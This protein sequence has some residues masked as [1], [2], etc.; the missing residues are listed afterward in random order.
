MLH[1]YQ[2]GQSTHNTDDRIDQISVGILSS[3]GI[4]DDVPLLQPLVDVLD[5]CPL[6]L[7]FMPLCPL[8][9]QPRQLQVPLLPSPSRGDDT[10]W[11]DVALVANDARCVG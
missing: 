6:T 5:G 9:L 8:I 10:E 11:A 7:E 4:G 2:I 3:I 1:Q